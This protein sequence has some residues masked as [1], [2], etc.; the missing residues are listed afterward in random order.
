MRPKSLLVGVVV[1]VLLSGCG[2]DSDKTGTSGGAGD[3]GKASPAAD[4]SA[5]ERVNLKA[6]DFPSGWSSRPHEKLPGEDELNPDIANCVGISPP[7]GRAT[8]EVRSPDFTQNMATASSVVTFVK[9]EEEAAADATAV[10]GDKFAECIRPGYEKQIHDVAPQPNT[11][12]NVT[13]TK[14]DLPPFGER[15]VAQRVT[16]QVH[17]DNLGIDLPVNVDVVRFFEGRAQVELVVV[18]PGQP[19]PN[20]LLSG[21]AGAMASRL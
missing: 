1:A 4:R 15:S 20:D 12:S 13:V 6:T 21:L 7:S 5:A 9:T 10:T 14:L 11:V 19:F 18:A 8:A 16:A 3:A 17:I 2:G